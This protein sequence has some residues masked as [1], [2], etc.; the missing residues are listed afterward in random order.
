M[1]FMP[2]PWVRFIP[3]RNF[4][5]ISLFILVTSKTLFPSFVKSGIINQISLFSL[6][7]KKIEIIRTCALHLCS[8]CIQT[9]DA[10]S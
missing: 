9:I 8:Y 6:S 5:W 3:F 2:T 1:L 4:I 7:E 10:D